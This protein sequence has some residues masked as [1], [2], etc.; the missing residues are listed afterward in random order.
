MTT[1]KQIIDT[2]PAFKDMTYSE[3]A[4]WFVTCPM[5]ENSVKEAP[6]VPK[7]VGLNDVFGAIL[8]AAPADMVKAGLI[9]DWMMDRA[10]KAME[11]NDRELMTN[12]LVS[13]SAVA[14]LS[15]ASKDALAAL[16]AET[17]PDT[18]WSKQ[19]PGIAYWQSVGLAYAP[20]A[21]DVQA[22]ILGE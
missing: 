4:K 2:E 9:P 3:I 17:V 10:E 18:S 22:A 21:R 13:I 8:Q 1:L 6:M 15:Q 19:I 5:V 16:L 7:R 12:W 14:G 20:S 11:N